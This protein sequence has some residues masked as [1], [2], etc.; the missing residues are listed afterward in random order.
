M[1]VVAEPTAPAF[2][3]VGHDLR[4]PPNGT[5][6]AQDRI[7]LFADA[8]GDHQWIHVDVDGPRPN[9]RSRRPIAHGYLTLSMVNLFLPELLTVERFD[10]ATSDLEKVRFPRRSPPGPGSE[11]AA[12]SWPSPRRRAGCR[13]RSRHR[14]A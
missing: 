4:A 5:T 6:V 8:T 7:A 11:P 10:G 3:M 9:R 13:S 2:A 12:R 14:G 1:T